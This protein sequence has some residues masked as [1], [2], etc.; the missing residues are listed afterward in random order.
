MYPQ[1][2]LAGFR[3][4]SNEPIPVLGFQIRPQLIGVDVLGAIDNR[5]CLG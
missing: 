3:L 5:F 1:E 4:D 2:V